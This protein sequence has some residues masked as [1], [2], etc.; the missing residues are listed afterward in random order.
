MRLG[1]TAVTKYDSTYK[2]L[3]VPFYESEN[4]N[5]FRDT[6]MQTIQK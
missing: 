1:G 5:E 3:G 4:E 6:L 2:I